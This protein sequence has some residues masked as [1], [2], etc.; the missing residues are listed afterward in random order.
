MR[1]HSPKCCGQPMQCTLPSRVRSKSRD[2]NDCE[3]EVESSVWQCVVCHV[4]KAQP[5][6]WRRAG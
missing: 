5:E 3:I 2:E 4:R 1:K 6:K